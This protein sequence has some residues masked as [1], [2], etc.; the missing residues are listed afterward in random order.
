M[1]SKLYLLYSLFNINYELTKSKKMSH[2]EITTFYKPFLLFFKNNNKDEKDSINKYIF[3]IINIISN[4]DKYV[5]ENILLFKNNKYYVNFEHNEYFLY[6]KYI[7][8]FSKKYNF[9]INKITCINDFDEENL[10]DDFDE[11]NLEDDSDEEN[12]ED[13]FDEENLEDDSDEE[14]LEDDSDEG[15]L[16]DNSDEENLE[17]NSKSKINNVNSQKYY[18]CESFTCNNYY[19]VS[20]EFTNCTCKSYEYCKESIKK[21]KHLDYCVKYNKSL[22]II[23]LN[24]KQCSCCEYLLKK[25]CKHLEYFL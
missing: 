15:N 13:D 12:L 20:K 7:N 18:V 25:Y 11:E 9:M 24:K 2:V 22:I 21:C 16:E 23:N 5:N 1:S 19:L 17:N 14:N 3:D 10:E 6:K 4:I 8:K